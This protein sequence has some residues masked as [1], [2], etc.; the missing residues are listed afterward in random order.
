M[1]GVTG[2][3]RIA[4]GTRLGSGYAPAAFF[5]S[6]TGLAYSGM[7]PGDVVLSAVPR[8]P[9][10]LAANMLAAAFLDDT[11]ADTLCLIDNDHVF[12]PDTLERLRSRPDGWQYDALGALYLVRGV[13]P[14]RPCI[15]R[16]ATGS[17]NRD[18]ALGPVDYTWPDAWPPGDVVACDALGLGF[19]LIRRRALESIP[20]PWSTFPLNSDTTSED[21]V[22]F[23][24]ARRAGFRLAVDTAVCIGH[25]L[26][27]SMATP[28]P[29]YEARVLERLGPGMGVTRETRERGRGNGRRK[30]TNAAA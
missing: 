18:H 7:R 10:H 4:I 29:E 15:F 27:A 16:Y 22:F 19:T 14:A 6:W 9:Q 28:G 1:A 25:L 23:N 30:R 3:G 17:D 11:T 26:D 21:M 12:R 13:Q 20:R 5:N 2:W 8:R 24:R